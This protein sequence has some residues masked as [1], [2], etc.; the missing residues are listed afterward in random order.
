MT[1]PQIYCPNNAAHT[2]FADQRESGGALCCHDCRRTRNIFVEALTVADP[3]PKW[4]RRRDAFGFTRPRR[5][6]RSVAAVVLPR[7]YTRT[8]GL[9]S[10]YAPRGVWLTRDEWRQLVNN[11]FATWVCPYCR[12]AGGRHCARHGVSK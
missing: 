12:S 1:V 8:T 7:R 3:A 2:A 10:T 4:K 9:G 5:L 11:W 6:I